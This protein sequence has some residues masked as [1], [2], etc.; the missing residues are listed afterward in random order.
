MER[1]NR[2]SGELNIKDKVDGEK[3]IKLK[4]A[5]AWRNLK[6]VQKQHK[7]LREKHMEELADCYANKRNTS[8]SSEVKKFFILS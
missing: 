3:F 8:R 2:L 1:I 4:L 6:K 5:E 7:V